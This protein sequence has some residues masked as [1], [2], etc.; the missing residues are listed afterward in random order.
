MAVISSQPELSAQPLS[1]LM[2][3]LGGNSSG[4]RSRAPWSSSS[5]EDELP[6]RRRGAEQGRAVSEARSETERRRERP[7]PLL[8]ALP[9][10]SC[11]QAGGMDARQQELSSSEDEDWDEDALWRE[12]MRSL[13]HLRRAS[14]GSEPPAPAREG[15]KEVA[16]GSRSGAVRGSPAAPKKDVASTQQ[17]N[18]QPELACC[19]VAAEFAAWAATLGEEQ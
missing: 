10:G 6:E 7:L 9:A 4:Q 15:R 12:R 1:R 17:G 2:G 3:L 14:Q 18:A 5:D 16:S 8:R 13:R 19:R 11:A